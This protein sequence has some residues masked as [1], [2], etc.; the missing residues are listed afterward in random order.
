MTEESDGIRP[1]HQV[2]LHLSI[3]LDDG[4]EVLSSFDGEP[5]TFRVGDGTIAPGLESLMLDLP[6]GS[7]TQ[8]LAAGEA[9]YGGPDPTLI[10]TID[11]R[12]L[13]EGFI[14]LRGQIVTFDT[15]G[16][17]ETAGTILETGADGTRVDFNHPLANRGLRVRVAVLAVD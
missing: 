3:H 13:P 1:G 5:L 6:V 7:D 16:G 15:P 9:V 12:D 17:Q 2:R 14:P 4:T 8:I 10:Q 11:P